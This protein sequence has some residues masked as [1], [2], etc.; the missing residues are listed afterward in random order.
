M[1]IRTVKIRS[2]QRP[3]TEQIKDTISVRRNIRLNYKISPRGTETLAFSEIVRGKTAWIARLVDETYRK[4]LDSGL[5][6]L[7]EGGLI[8]MNVPEFRPPEF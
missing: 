8:P 6:Y 7:N 5:P 2:L 4:K 1:A 3:A